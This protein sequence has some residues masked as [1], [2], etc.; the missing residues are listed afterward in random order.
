MCSIMGYS[1]QSYY[2]Q[3]KEDSKAK[4]QEDIVVHLV[5][6]ERTQCAKI[7]GRNLHKCLENDL[8]KYGIAIG[9]DKFFDLLRN[10]GLLVKPWRN[11]ARTTDSFHHYHKFENLVPYQYI[12]T[13]AN[14][15]WVSD[16]TYIW[17]E[18]DRKFCYLSLITDMYSRKIVGYCVHNDLSVNGCIEALEMALS[19]RKNKA[20][21]LIHH[22]DRGV[23]YCCK[24]YV[25]KLKRNKIVISMTQ[26]G[27]PKENAIAERVNRTIKC[28][29]TTDGQIHYKDVASAKIGVNK[30]V[31]YYNNRK[32]HS[33][34]ERLTPNEA[35]KQKGELKRKWK[36]YYKKKK[37]S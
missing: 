28:D 21:K 26:S 7:S 20:E 34:V 23:Q 15:I 31:N 3:L 2:A 32:P 1:K 11:K 29:F 17:L 4:V 33:S 12:C 35:H 27:D 18:Q 24:A 8:K 9:R 37:V 19:Q 30:N 5:K 36:T 14:E 10:N 16:I 22:S 25:R 6:Q 13:R